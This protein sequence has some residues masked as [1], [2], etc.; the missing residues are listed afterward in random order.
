[1]LLEDMSLW[2]SLNK[3]IYDKEKEDDLTIILFFVEIVAPLLTPNLQ[4]HSNQIFPK[5]LIY[6]QICKTPFANHCTTL[7]KCGYNVGTFADILYIC[8][9]EKFEH[10]GS[11]I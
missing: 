9:D 3:R 4:P 11:F 2:Y 1:M 10:Y 6:N 8:I 5:S 7:Q